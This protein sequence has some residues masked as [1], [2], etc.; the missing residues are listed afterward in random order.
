MSSR[1]KLDAPLT[2]QMELHPF[3]R[4][5]AP[6]LKTI[7]HGLPIPV[8]FALTCITL[9]LGKGHDAALSHWAPVAAN[10]PMVEF[11]PPQGI[12]AP[13]DQGPVAG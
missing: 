8:L 3:L 2:K 13:R 12:S 9:T 4:G 5:T 7:I 6:S 10:R 1:V 11:S